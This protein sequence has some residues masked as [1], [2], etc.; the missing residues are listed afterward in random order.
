[1][2]SIIIMTRNEEKNIGNMLQSIVS[3][4]FHGEY[5]IL[6]V[7]GNSSDNTKN[8]IA[9]FF[10]LLPLRIINGLSRG[11]GADRN[12]GGDLCSGDLM[13]FTEGDC[14]L[15]KG[16]LFELSRMFERKGLMAW[17]TVTIPNKSSGL[18]QFTYKMYDVAR[19]LLTKLPYPFKGYSVSGAVLVVRR[20][21]WD[22]I[23]GFQEGSD[24]NDDGYMGRKIRDHY[25]GKDQFMFSINPKYPIYRI[26]DR[27]NNGYFKTLNHYIYVLVNFFPFL[28][29]Y[30]KN[31]MVYEG[32][33]FKHEKN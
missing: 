2:L 14:Y 21:V 24:M 19:Y 17:S 20:K 18:I 8:I 26:M 3:Q 1:M 32:K 23:G 9:G 13:F 31:Q 30:L 6:I 33:R 22:K 15:N 27:F 29:R 11:I 25:R 4:S 5:E 28:V 10:H 12:L 7:D 16:F